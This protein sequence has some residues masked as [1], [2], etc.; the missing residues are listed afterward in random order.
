[1]KHK[2]ETSA[3]MPWLKP[4]TRGAAIEETCGQQAEWRVLLDLTCE[5]WRLILA[6]SVIPSSHSP[7][8]FTD[9]GQ[10]SVL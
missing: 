9:A 3:H 5:V 1:M 10:R 6:R 4:D 2:A 7:N 8:L